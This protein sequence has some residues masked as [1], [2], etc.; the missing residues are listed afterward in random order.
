[1]LPATLAGTARAAPA[2]QPARPLET[3][4]VDPVAFGAPD[5]AAAFAHVREAGATVVRLVLNWAAV[6]P[7]GGQRPDGFRPALPD[8]PRYRWDGFDLQVRDAVAAGL[9]PLVDI[10]GAPAWAQRSAPSPRP[11]DGPYRPSYKQLAAF[12]SAAAK[13]YSGAFENLPRVRLWQVWNEPNF[14]Y[15]LTPQAVG[16]RLVSTG[17]YR[18]MLNASARAIHAVHQDNLVVAGGLAPYG[19]KTDTLDGTAPLKFMRQ[20]LCMS[21]GPRPHR[22]CNRT[23]AFDVWSHHPYTSGG[24]T[25]RA[26]RPDDVSIGDLGE[27]NALLR[28]A[29]QA[30]A[31]QSAHRV[32]FWVTEFSWDTAP[33]DPKGLPMALHARWVAEA[34]YRMWEDGVSLVTWYLIRDEPFPQISTQSGLYFRGNDGVESDRP[35]RSLRAFRF[36]FVAFREKGGKISFWGRT[37]PSAPRSVV[38]ERAT[39]GAWRAVARLR[40]SAA[41]VFQGHLPDAGGGDRLR[42]R[43]APSGA[44][45]LPFSLHVPP[46]RDICPFGTC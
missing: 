36:P 26:G 43:V 20:L 30:G 13:R 4:V 18:A 7:E 45:S 38:V 41:G 28:A 32:R 17:W 12:A 44:R 16:G 15:Y 10:N 23:V 31:I 40:P 19:T 24:P 3:A 35:K 2:A 42:A 22:T 37:P 33:P 25:R 27:M 9:A 11:Q 14:S 5:P 6:A 34:L 46:D 1:M 8:D 21:G 39:S 29:E